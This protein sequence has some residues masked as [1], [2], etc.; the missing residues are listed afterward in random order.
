MP[1]GDTIAKV[2][3]VLR[4]EL[5]GEVLT[6]S[7]VRGV[8]GSERLAG[9]RVT[10][11]ETLGKHLLVHFDRDLLLRVHLGMHGRWHRYPLG[12]PWRR[13]AAAAVVLE[14]GRVRVVCYEPM[15]VEM[16]PA[17]QR[18][19]HRGLQRLGPD[20][21]SPEEPDWAAIA[22]RSRVYAAPEALL[23]EVL[24]DQ[25]IA[26]G[27]GNVYKSEL[28]FMGSLE[29]DVF[30]LAAKAWSP[31]LPWAQ[32][33]A[34]DYLGLL[35]RARGLLQANLGGWLRTTRV[36]RRLQSEPPG[37]PLYVYGRLGKPCFRCGTAI[38]RAHQG[39][40]ARVTYWCPACQPGSPGA[41]DREPGLVAEGNARTP[42]RPPR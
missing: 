26:A 38:V 14:T 12:V 20:L 18:R 35:R 30:R 33:D 13:S 6:G 10:E 19:W 41:P 24:L 28:A 39:D 36:D 3:R 2:A 32:L 17:P 42:G 7:L 8:Y 21:L 16:I 22:V 11:I 4:R 15:E 27:I 1:E 40:Q 25:R 23:G 5:E 34:D 29:G 37:G 31:W 9:C